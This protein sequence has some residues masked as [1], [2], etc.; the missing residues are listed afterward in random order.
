MVE[1]YSAV[2][3]AVVIHQTQIW[4]K[5]NSYCLKA[6]LVTHS[7]AVAVDLGETETLYVNTPS[8]GADKT[9]AISHTQH[10][11]GLCS[12]H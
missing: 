5:A 2:W 3:P 10:K 7:E 11:T 4:E 6:S 8:L 1:N 9:G 12:L